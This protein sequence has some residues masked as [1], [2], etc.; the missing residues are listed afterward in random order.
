VWLDGIK[1]EAARRG[2]R[3]LLTG[4]RGNMSVSYHGLTLLGA[5]AGSGRWLRLGREIAA[6]RASRAPWRS[7]ASQSLGPH[8]PRWLWQ[9]V[10]ASRRR[11]G[12]PN[13]VSM[14]APEAGYRW[15]LAKNAA[16][17]GVDPSY[18]PSHDRVAR[19]LF[20]L[21]GVDYGNYNKGTLAGWGIEVRDPTSDRELVEFCLRVP[22]EQYLRLGTA[23]W[24]AKRAMADRIPASVLY[25]RGKGYQAADWHEVVAANRDRI[26]DEVSRIATVAENGEILDLDRMHG[27]LR[28]WPAG[29]WNRPEVIHDYR[30]ALLRGI[31]AGSFVSYAVRNS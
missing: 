23:R 17:S 14:L 20:S 30:L 28:D 18:Q 11:S 27:L 9:V 25:A 31:A 5:L 29:N 19:R 21:T 2:L 10:T 22:D 13:V 12:L 6:L 16:K 8:L 7:L 1:D 4:A 15:G 24:L 3:V 26:A